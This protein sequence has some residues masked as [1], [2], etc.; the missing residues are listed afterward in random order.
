MTDTP[1]D[2]SRTSS[3]GKTAGSRFLRLAGMTARISGDVAR[4]RWQRLW[5]QNEDRTAADAALYR[6]IGHEIAHTLGDMK[7]AVMKVGQVVS[8]YRDVLP[9]ELV[10]A[11]T[12]LQKDSP[13]RP[14]AELLP[15]LQQ[16][17]GADWRDHFSQFDET[18]LASAS[19]AQVHRARTR[20]GRDVVLKIQYPGVEQAIDSDLKQLRL[21]LKIA[22]VLPISGHL[23]DAL[24]DEIRTSLERELDYDLEAGAIRRFRR[25]H[26]DQPQ[27][28][29]PEVI[30]DLSSRH[31]LTLSHEPGDALNALD[32]RYD[33]P[34]RDA[35]GRLLFETLAR[36]L[37]Q[38][39][40]LH[41]DP[42]PGNFAA[43]PDGSL[44]VYDFG[45]LKELPE[46]LVQDYAALTRA[47]LAQ[48][49]AAVEDS[50]IRLGA[51]NTQHTPDLPDGFY[52]PWLQLAG[53]I[54]AD[55]PVDF[56][57][58]PL[59]EQV[60]RLSRKALPQWRAFQPVPD[61]VLVNRALGG[62]YWNLRQLGA[63]VA[64][65]PLL[66]PLAGVSRA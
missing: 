14:F 23:L 7:G 22:R 65:R 60:L 33:Q 40:C 29:I 31:V 35:L 64:M 38:L 56:A 20:D 45:C 24:F 28:V 30:P 53:D 17:L 8:Q 4:D 2:A 43:R 51:R 66:Q 19:I 52:R 59:A 62:H 26:A 46:D 6:R 36:Q 39:R 11:L 34:R 57:T 15:R 58:W 16:A 54:L 3:P 49:P 61:L 21:A 50:L 9:A 44:V 18:A 48:D 37:Y 25:F 42:H 27:V 63:N 1:A 55:T 10:D 47:A 12:P 32:E 5:R 13:P 41:C